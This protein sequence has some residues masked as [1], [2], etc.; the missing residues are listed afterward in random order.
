MGFLTRPKL[1]RQITLFAIS[2]LTVSTIFRENV[3]VEPSHPQF[4]A[5][6]NPVVFVPHANEGERRSICLTSECF[7]K[8][9]GLLARAFPD[10]PKVSWCIP[11]SRPEENTFRDGKWQGLLLVKVPKAASSTA[12]GLTLRIANQTGC[13]VQFEHREGIEY[14]ERH[15]ESFLLGT[16][17]R[18]AARAFSM[19]YFFIIAPLNITPTDPNIIRSINTRRGGKTKGKGGYMF[20]YMSLRPILPHS[21]WK[22]SE[23]TKVQ[24]ETLVMDYV[25]DIVNRYDFLM[26]VERMDESLT[27]LALVA[28]LDLG[29]VLSTSAKVS[30]EY[31]LARSGK[32]EGRCSKQA[33]G[34]VS[35]GMEKYFETKAWLAMNYADYVLYEAANRSLDLTIE[36]IGRDRFDRALAELRRLKAKAT[37]VCGDHVGLGCTGDGVALPENT[38]YVRDFGCGHKCVDAM[39]RD[40]KRSTSLL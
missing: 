19:A 18:P 32:N 21:V 26:V 24:N 4:D 31:K 8:Q 10:R 20:K 7:Q 5:P 37:Q 15:A 3:P 33:K 34:R 28:G 27:A 22:P 39:L 9:G 1:V 6:I 38:C 11:A 30:G 16:V 35:K 12:A 40:E 36:Q 25:Q 23:P 17:R 2:V 14:S 29:D 13:A